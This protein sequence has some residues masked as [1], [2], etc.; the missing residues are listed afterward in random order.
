MNEKKLEKIAN[1]MRQLNPARLAG[2]G[3][4]RIPYETDDEITD[5]IK[6]YLELDDGGKRKEKSG[7]V[8]TVTRNLC[9][10]R[11]LSEWFH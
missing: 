5:L 4:S 3:A 1:S 6:R 11:S 7:K 2:W 9:S 10:W 8:L